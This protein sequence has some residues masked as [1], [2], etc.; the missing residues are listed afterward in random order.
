MCS[1]DAICSWRIGELVQGELE[2]YGGVTP[3]EIKYHNLNRRL[4]LGLISQSKC[5]SLFAVPLASDLTAF[6]TVQSGD[7]WI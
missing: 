6:A 1:R 5:K 7:E 3:L 2:I 4:H